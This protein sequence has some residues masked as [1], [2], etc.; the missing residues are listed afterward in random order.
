[1]SK[2]EELTTATVEMG[3]VPFLPIMPT[4]SALLRVTKDDFGLSESKI[5]LGGLSFYLTVI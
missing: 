5:I 4:V 1:M 2:L 3:Q